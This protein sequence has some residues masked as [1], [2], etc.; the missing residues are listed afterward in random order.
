[1]P[2]SSHISFLLFLKNEKNHSDLCLSFLVQHWPSGWVAEF[3]DPMDDKTLDGQRGTFVLAKHMYRVVI[4][5]HPSSV[6][7]IAKDQSSCPV[8]TVGPSQKRMA[9]ETYKIF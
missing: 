3:Q 7:N 2:H 9:S 1:M 6:C 8:W 5:S 4:M